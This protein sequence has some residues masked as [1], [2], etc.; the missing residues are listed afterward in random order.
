MTAPV[1]FV[2]K[3][4]PRLSE[5]FIAQEIRALE[6]R[7]LDIRLYSLRRP[8]DAAVHPIHAEIAAPVVYLPEYLRDEPAR[9]TAAWRRARRLPGYRSAW[10]TWR[11]DFRR[12]RSASRIRRFGQAVV[13]AA[14][15]DPDVGGLHAHFLH[16]PASVT[17]YA[18]LMLG[19]P[20]TVSAHA[21]DVWTIP[22]WEKR[23]KLACC[24]WLATCSQVNARHLAALAP[25]PDR[26]RLAYHGLD[27][28]RFPPPP[29]SRVARDGSDQTGPVTIVT[30]GRAV[31]KKGHDVLIEALGRL[32]ADLHWRW[33]HV[34]DGPLLPALKRQ[35]EAA[36]LSDRVD[37]LGARPQ[38]DVLAALRRADLFVLACRIG[39][40]G[41]RDGLPNVLLEAQSQA[42]ACV[43]TSVSA[44]NELIEDDRT[45][46]LV[47]PDDVEG[48]AIAMARLIC[49]PALRQRLGRA[50]LHRVHA[51][52]AME[53][54]IDRLAAWFGLQ[55]QP[56]RCASPST[57]H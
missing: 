36:G 52:F 51:A 31:E 21:K 3:G 25:E 29:S 8:T 13:L 20:W 22:E 45:G 37:W 11:R 33:V 15:L 41:D 26:V 53:P 55:Q 2:L 16:T 7:G 35:A 5:T 48:L 49:E 28:S 40:D 34:G 14:E 23:E 4:Y 43:A 39:A 6:R 19:L 18:A 57:R 46:L 30:V 24:R 54:G 42:L 38:A 27:L 10:E 47:P 17:R 1:A 12:D 44:I 9:V 32:P 56:A 50:G